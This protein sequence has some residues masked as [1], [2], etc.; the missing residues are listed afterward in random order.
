MSPPREVELKLDVPAH[1]LPLLTASSLL[2]GA[3]KS[4][5]KLVNLVSVYFDTDKLKL[6]QK[7]LSLRVRRIGRHHV[8]TIKQE[9]SGDVALF[10]RGQW[11]HNV[12][13]KQPDLDAARGTALAPLLNKSLRR[14]LKPMFETHVN[15]KIFQI[16]TGESEIELSI[17]KGKIEAGPKSLPLCE[18]EL[19]LKRGQAAD[20]FKLAKVLAHEAP[21]QLAVKSKADRGY[22]LLTAE[23]ATPVK[24]MPVA[25]AAESKVQDAFQII[26]R[27]G[28][29]QLA[30]NQSLMIAGDADA[31]H[32][33]R[34]ALRRLRTAISLFSDMLTDPQTEAL[35]SELKWIT[36]ELGAARE[37]EVLMKR[38]GPVTD[39]GRG[40]LGPPRVSQEL[41][42]KRDGALA[43]AQRWKAH[44][45]AILLSRPQHGSRRVIGRATWKNPQKP[46]GNAHSQQWLQ[47]NCIA[48]ARSS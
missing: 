3:S 30:A 5:A 28:L 2:K 24:A 46:C 35:K 40:G 45:F 37:F 4:R 31:L 6:R 44:V 16:R 29:H 19:E 14:T 13:G 10:A 27:A 36:A 38:V 48:A 7:G 20:L 22:A 21:V 47:S 11:E 41:R 15:R 25:I 33:M 32:Q 12:H 43:R 18:V 39:G 1:S 17:D 23:K 26:A 42:Q 8:Q 34:V 9:N